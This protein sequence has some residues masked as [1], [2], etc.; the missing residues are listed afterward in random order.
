YLSATCQ[1]TIYHFLP[2]FLI[3][4]WL[5]TKPSL[6]KD[7]FVDHFSRF[8]AISLR[9]LPSFVWGLVVLMVFYGWLAWF[10][11]GRLSLEADLYVKSPA[12]RPYTHLLTLDALL[13]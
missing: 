4:L 1:C 13:N 5:C 3:G 6:H 7:R 2:H 10:P 8:V 11:P 12:F 9:G